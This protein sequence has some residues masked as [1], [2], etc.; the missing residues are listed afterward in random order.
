MFWASTP[1][2]KEIFWT[3]NLGRSTATPTYNYD[4][5][6]TPTMY[7]SV[8][9]FQLTITPV[10]Q[11]PDFH[12]YNASGLLEYHIDVHAAWAAQGRRKGE[13]GVRKAAGILASSSDA[14]TS[15]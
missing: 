3:A 4:C 8:L 11:D 13:R 7:C 5:Y 2:G 10:L 12:Y 6:N 15:S 9:I 1:L 14:N